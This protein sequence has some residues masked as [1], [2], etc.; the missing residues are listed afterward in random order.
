MPPESASPTALRFSKNLD[1]LMHHSRVT[2]VE[3]AQVLGISPEYVSRLRHQP[4]SRIGFEHLDR[5]MTYFNVDPNTL[6][7]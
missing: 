2:N 6:L 1:H 4:I 3:L 7:T 5:L